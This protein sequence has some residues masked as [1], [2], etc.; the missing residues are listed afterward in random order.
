MKM[1][2]SFWSLPCRYAWPT[3]I[4]PPIQPPR[5]QPPIPSARPVSM[6]KPI[7]RRHTGGRAATAT[8]L[9]RSS[10]PLSGS[11][12]RRREVPTVVGRQVLLDRR[13]LRL[14]S[15]DPRLERGGAQDAAL[16]R[17]VPVPQTAELRTANLEEARLASVDVGDVVDSGHSV[18]L[19]A[20]LVRPERM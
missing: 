2:T 20:E 18:G 13:V 15:G 11:P 8:E 14:R 5:N 1:P 16:L 3:A 9:T 7:R 12:E 10:P 17:H 6:L 4:C 19:H